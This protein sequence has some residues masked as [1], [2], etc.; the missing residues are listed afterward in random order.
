MRGSFAK[1]LF[2]LSILANLLISLPVPALAHQWSLDTAVAD[3]GVGGHAHRHDVAAPE[4]LCKA[5]HQQLPSAGGETCHCQ[6]G[7]GSPTLSDL[8]TG[9]A[10]AFL[11]RPDHGRPSADQIVASGTLLPPLRPPRA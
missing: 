10:L 5:S 7:L 8:G 1:A 6:T 3:D 9:L 4:Q 11:L 2:A